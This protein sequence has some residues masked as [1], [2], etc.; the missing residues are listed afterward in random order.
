M[1][2]DELLSELIPA[3]VILVREQKPEETKAVLTFLRVCVGAVELDTLQSM[4]P[5]MMAVLFEEVGPLKDKF[6]LR[7]KCVVLLLSLRFCVRMV[8]SD[9]FTRRAIILRLGRKLG[10]DALRGFIPESDQPLL[11]HIE[12]QERRHQKNRERAQAAGGDA[13][14]DGS[15]DSDLSDDDSDEDEEVRI[16]RPKVTVADGACNIL[17]FSFP[18]FLSA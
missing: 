4:L 14:D 9:G 2:R 8:S 10:F 3:V 6:V 12:R 1:Q 7:I 18:R 15:D 11:T 16:Q 13:G 17:S 5:M